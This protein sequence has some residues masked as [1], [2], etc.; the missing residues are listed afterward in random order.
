MSQ[1]PVSILLVSWLFVYSCTLAFVTSA[2]PTA[3]LRNSGKQLE[4]RIHG[5]V[6]DSNGQP[7]VDFGVSGSFRNSLSSQPFEPKIIGNRFEAWLPVNATSAF[8]GWIKVASGDGKR[9]AIKTLAANEFRQSAIDGIKMTLKE[10]NRTVTVSV[11][12]EGR[13]V[14]AAIVKAETQFGIEMRGTTDETGKAQLNLI[15]EQVLQRFTV[16]TEDRRIGGFS[17]DREPKRDPDLSEFVVEISKCRDFKMRLVDENGVAAVDVPFR[18]Q[19]ATPAPNYNFIGLHDHSDLRTDNAGEAVFTWMPEWE[20]HNYIELRS[21]EWILDGEP[22]STGDVNIYK[23]KR[24]KI[25]DRKRIPGQLDSSETDVGGFQIQ[26]RSFQGERENHSDKLSTF[27]NPDGTFEFDV[28]PDATYCFFALDTQW[29][30]EIIDVLPYDS[31]KNQIKNP[32]LRISKGQILEV[33]VDTGSQKTP[34]P[35][36]SINL[37]RSH[38]YSWQENE[39]TRNGIGGP[40]WWLN[41]DESGRAFTQVPPGEVEVSV[42][43]PL[44][45]TNETVNVLTEKPAKVH[46]HRQEEDEKNTVT[47]RLILPNGNEI[48]LD[49][50]DIHV[51]SIDGKHKESFSIKANESGEFSFS[52]FASELAF[53]A[54]SQDARAA[55]TLVVHDIA[56]PI[57]IQLQPTLEYRGQLLGEKDEPLKDIEV[58][59]SVQLEGRELYDNSMYSKRFDAKSINA[60]T[61]EHGNYRIVGLPAMTKIR[62]SARSLPDPKRQESLDEV[63]LEP[64]ESRPVQVS[65]LGKAVIPPATLS[66]SDRVRKTQRDCALSGFHLLVIASANTQPVTRFIQDNLTNSALANVP[67]FMH[68]TISLEKLE[69][70]R[71][72]VEYFDKRNWLRPSGD[73]IF[74]CAVDAGDKVLGQIEFDAND[75]DAVEESAKFLAQHAPKQVNAENKWQEAFEEA[76][77]TDRKVWAR[78]SQRYCGP[79]FSLARWLDESKDLLAKDFV[80]LKIDNVRDENGSSVAKRLTRGKH[81]GVPFHAIFD[82][83][84]ELVIDSAGPLGNVG[85]PSGSE[86]KKQLRKMLQST[87]KNITD[88][89]IDQLV[90]SLED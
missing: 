7:V 37:R 41:T 14:P 30:C 78:I 44:W 34:I 88:S 24:S 17:F 48:K 90:D 39:R 45:R 79:C 36:L 32:K 66:L 60:R 18:L 19:I 85:H 29:V 74:I 52:A 51:G 81:H 4:M 15:A 12:Y 28:L 57:T 40:Q 2:E 70:A 6:L 54:Y 33:F 71:E 77:R 59:A 8:A 73:K 80:M 68:L 84:G 3:W 58:V 16:W 65:K 69:D 11:I 1:R 55:G 63:F 20:S 89:E 86:G 27:S 61:D 21:D 26:A 50:V 25:R 64:K 83:Q 49:Q 10:S 62:M 67:S 53:L 13:P 9:T 82:A 87:K 35:N 47:G 42:Y 43:A 75:S 22:K 76:E 23:L 46:L 5:E 31:Y 38:R 56:N 72:D